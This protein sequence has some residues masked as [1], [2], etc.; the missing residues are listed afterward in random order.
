MVTMKLALLAL[1]AS[2][3]FAQSWTPQTSGVTASL[4]GVSAVS[5]TVVWASGSGGTWLLTTD[6]GD[7][8]HSGKVAGAERLDFRAIH[9]FDP[10]TAIV[11]SIGNGESSRVYKTTDA[12][13]TWKLLFTNPDAK[14][15]FD[16]IAFW[17]A[18]HGI[19][20]GDPVDGHTVIYTTDDGGDHWDRQIT[21]DAVGA[22]G[23]FAASNTSM[24]LH[25]SSE[26]WLGTTAAR[27]WHSTDR[28]RTWKTAATPVRNDGSSSG[29]FSVAF[30]DSKT[31]IAVGGDYSKDKEDKQNIA[32]T[33]DGGATWTAPDARPAGF[34]SAAAWVGD[35]KMWVVTGTSGSDV[36]LDGGATWKN[37]DT[38]S[39]NALA[40]VSSKAGWAVGGR[41]RIARFRID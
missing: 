31:G 26:V 28:G 15:F 36:S 34:R 11:L 9:A 20:C 30:L 38:G 7:T 21:P 23:A 35:K 3:A 16:G 18:R 10:K 40:F 13:A 27:V 5:D 4:R 39:F 37:F 24:T 14:G 6:G 19:L 12:G 25:G 2:A 8:W 17:D 41:G 1:T 29:I 33:K 32:I 22:E